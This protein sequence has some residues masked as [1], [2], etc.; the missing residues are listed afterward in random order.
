[1]KKVKNAHGKTIDYD[2]A[3]ILMDD[4]LREKLHNNLAPCS[5]QEFFN[6][7]CKAHM[8]KYG[9]EFEPNKPNPVW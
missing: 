1:M 8:A 4:D 6:E 5:A 3:V 7:Y 2:A 9:Q